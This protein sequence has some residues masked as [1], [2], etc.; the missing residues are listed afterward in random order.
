MEP[1]DALPGG[2]LTQLHVLVVSQ[3]QDDV[4]PDVPAV[5]LEAALEAVVGQE[6]RAPAQQGEDGG[7][8]QAEQ[9][10]GGRHPSFRPLRGS[11]WD[12]ES[13]AA[14]WGPYSLP[15]SLLTHRLG[16]KDRNGV[17]VQA[18]LALHGG[19]RRLV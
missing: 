5:P 11:S 8:Q 13:E 1:R 19:R 17:T 18:L 14:S 3:H 2:V 16:E 15:S 4:G 6:G 12:V 10:A 9:Q 7:G